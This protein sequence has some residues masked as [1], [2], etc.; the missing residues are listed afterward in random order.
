MKT[1]IIITILF[2]A[3][4]ACMAGAFVTYEPEYCVNCDDDQALYEDLDITWI[5]VVTWTTY[6]YAPGGGGV[7]VYDAQPFKSLWECTREIA[8]ID[9]DVDREH[10]GT[11]IFEGYPE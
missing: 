9:R 5:C 10:V 2:F 3:A 1:L 11:C 4:P 8:R 7:R 6:L